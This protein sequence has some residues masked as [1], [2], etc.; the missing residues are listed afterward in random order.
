MQVRALEP[1]P[2]RPAEGLVLG[3]GARAL[4]HRHQPAR[5]YLDVVVEEAQQLGRGRLD[6]RVAG[7]VDPPRFSERDVAAAVPAHEPLGLG[8]RHVVLDDHDVRAVRRRLRRHRLKR[9]R[10][11]IAPGPGGDQYRGGRGHR[12][13]QLRLGV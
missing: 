10:E 12:R 9:H 7:G 6:G 13:A 2:D 11:V 3:I 4:Q 8:I 5:P 1:G